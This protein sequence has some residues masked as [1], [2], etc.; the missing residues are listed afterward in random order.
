MAAVE[1]MPMMA[2]SL[3]HLLSTRM[4]AATHR[5]MYG[6]RVVIAEALSR[7]TSRSMARSKSTVIVVHSNMDS[8]GTR[9]LLSRAKAGTYFSA[10]LL[11]TSGV[12]N[13]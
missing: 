6:I 4:K 3:T 7:K 12:P 5:K 11:M 1:T 13:R 10:K 2:I 9:L 8:I